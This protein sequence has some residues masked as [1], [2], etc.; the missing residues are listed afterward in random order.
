MDMQ[1]PVRLMRKDNA[2]T[3]KN[4]GY[5]YYDGLYLVQQAI[6]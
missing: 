6:N 3:K 2:G 4:G 5:R 1:K